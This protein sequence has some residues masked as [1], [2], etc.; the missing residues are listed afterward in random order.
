MLGA[1]LGGGTF[2]QDAI[3]HIEPCSK[4][5]RRVDAIW[6]K[7]TC[8]EENETYLWKSRRVAEVDRSTKGRFDIG[9]DECL[10]TIEMCLKIIHTASSRR[11]KIHA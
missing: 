9:E 1:G 3:D 4:D 2:S 8:H 11:L 7:H 5:H 6:A 10:K